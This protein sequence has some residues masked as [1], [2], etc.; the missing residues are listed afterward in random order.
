MADLTLRGQSD[1]AL[2][3][4]HSGEP[5]GASAIGRR[6]LLAFPKHVGTYSLLGQACLA[7]GAHEEAANLFRR[8]LSADPEH[9][10]A[11]ACLAAIYAERGLLEEATWQLERAVELSPANQEMRREL[12][13]L[14]AERGLM[15]PV[16]LRPTRAALAR[17]YLRG[18]LYPK[19]VGELRDL[20]AD[21]GYR[22][23]LRVALAE[24][25]WRDG[26]PAEAS[27]VAQNILAELPNCLKANLILGQVWLHT[28][29]DDDAR[30]LLQRAQA[31][32]PENAMAQTLFGARS[33]LPPRMARLSAR[34][35]ESPSVELP[36]L[37]DDEDV[38]SESKVIEGRLGVQAAPVTEPET[39][40]PD[41]AVQA[42]GPVTPAAGEPL[43]E[44]QLPVEGLTGWI[45][46]EDVFS[47]DEEEGLSLI[48]VRRAYVADHPDDHQARLDLARRLC[49]SGDVT[50]AA[51]HYGY[52]VQEAHSLLPATIHDLELLKRLYPSMAIF[53]ELLIA[54]HLRESRQPQ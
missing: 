49:G 1:E 35:E 40:T 50:Q 31:L 15:L 12:R 39:L 2:R 3:L 37:V 43:A 28:D 18:Q 17:T 33:P 30:V 7:L 26:R 41:V 45:A 54:A 6:I 52:L 11:Y 14:Y 46:D 5:A 44:I 36:Y 13:R 8:V 22:L 20:V 51:Q 25:L 19:A 16:R 27:S 42:P 34:P 4:L 29:R 9:T 24:A 53:E 23:D 38:V 47:K 10:L 21:E 32:D 48:D